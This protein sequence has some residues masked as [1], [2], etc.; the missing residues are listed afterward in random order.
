MNTPGAGLKSGIGRIVCCVA[1]LA[2]LFSLSG[3]FSSGIAYADEPATSLTIKLNGNE[4]STLTIAELEQLSQVTQGY[5]SI[6][7]LP[8]PCMTAARGVKVTDVL[9]EAGIDVGTVKNLTFVST[10]GYKTTI[11]KEYLLDTERYYYPNLT[12]CFDDSIYPQYKDGMEDGKVQVQPVLAIESHYKRFDASPA[13]DKM[14]GQCALRLCFGQGTPDE[15]TSGRFAKYVCE[16]DVECSLSPI[17]FTIDGSDMETAVYTMAEL[18]AMPATER[19]YPGKGGT[20]ICQ[21]VSLKDLLVSLG[22]TNGDLMAQISIHDAGSFTV[23]PVPVADLLNED[24][25]YLLTYYI[26]GEPVGGETQLS[27]YRA[28]DSAKE[29]TIKN[30]YG[31][32]ISEPLVFGSAPVL[33]ADTTDNTIGQPINITF[34][35]NEAWRNAITTVEVGDILLE[36]SQYTKSAGKITIDASVFTGAGVY[37]I[38]IKAAG[39]EDTSVTQIINKVYETTGLSITVDNGEAIIVTA[40]QINIL[41]N[42]NEIRHYSHYKDGRMNYC[43]GLGA[44]LAAIL[45]QY[46]AVESSNIQSLT[47]GADDYFVTFA[48]AQNEVFNT[49]FYYPPV[50]ERVEIDAI[51]ATKASESLITDSSQLDNAHTM[52]LMLGQTDP[53]ERT[54]SQ[55]VKWVSKIDI[56]TST[57]AN[58]PVT[59]ISLNKSATTLVINNSEQLRVAI[60]PTAATSQTVTWASSNEAVATVDNRGKV[61]ALEAG[62]AVITVATNDG[63][64]SASCIVTVILESAGPLYTVTPVIDN[65]YTSTTLE[66]VRTMIVNGGVSGINYF[67]VQVEPIIAHEGT[68][69][70]VFIHFRNG[71][72]LSLNATQ[73]DFDI[74]HIAQAGFNVLPSDQVKVYIVDELTNAV[75]SNPVI[76]Q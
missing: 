45:T 14:E 73:A 27:I 40:E 23:D 61:T 63:S 46:A 6:D 35:D 51:I 7:S 26:D 43:T 48:D 59:E 76:L 36:N 34:T 68:E 74:V 71:V 58:I 75:D 12:E 39:Y 67:A 8:A 44:P 54:V 22:I 30:A 11:S 42:N 16:L 3:V 24:R 17:I 69:T 41:N 19:N 21:G 65:A 13:F 18:Q 62:E 32:T 55:M 66:E 28:A 52:R 64:F 15:Q 20:V 10:D 2:L 4:V 37:T 5:S 31:I 70:V 33:T 29:A 57:A 47:V 9:A 50:G 53:E 56:V 25:A 72:P 1:M 60:K 49:R 38:I